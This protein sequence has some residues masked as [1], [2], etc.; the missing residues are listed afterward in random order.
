MVGA[1]NGT[2]VFLYWRQ[3]R[4]CE[5]HF[6]HL[7]RQQVTHRPSARKR[8]LQGEIEMQASAFLQMCFAA[9]LACIPV[10][11]SAA[12][13]SSGC[14]EAQALDSGT[15]IT[16]T[17]QSGRTFRI[18]V[19]KNYDHGS[20][21]RLV[22]IFHGWGGNENEFLGNRTVRSEADKRGYILVA[23]RGLGSG[24]PDNSYNSWSFSGST[25]GLDGDNGK[26]CD[27]SITPDYSYNSCA[28]VKD[29]SCSWTQCTANDVEFAVALVE[30]IK[31]SL[32]IDADNI[33]AT[34]G[35]N[36]GMFTWELGQ[37]QSAGNGM[38]F[39]A[40]APLIGLPHRGYLDTPATAVIMPALVIT[41]TRDKVVP[42]GAWD[43]DTF[44]T[45][46]NG[47][48]RYYYTG[49]T[50][51]TQAWALAAECSMPEKAAAFDDG[52][53]KADCRT[54][55]PEDASGGGWPRVLDCRARMGHS[56]DL[57]WTWKLIMDFFDAHSAP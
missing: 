48:D 56:Y 7:D 10:T 11:A 16:Q 25:T 1:V 57:R 41:G 2:F 45:T 50:G 20:P 38:M 40:I 34:G 18:H 22:T 55:C 30:E 8:P 32:C 52:Y 12:T 4:C 28:E 36:G 5:I 47:R 49:A 44:T 17:A 27:D 42:P 46:S 26:I 37:N 15:H 21:T 33:F 6:Q 54:H 19:P 39:R 9:L 29:N 53:R 35:S 31:A 43:D 3:T 13:A 23:P 24:S 51:I 14:D